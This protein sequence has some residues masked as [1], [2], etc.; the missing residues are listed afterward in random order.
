MHIHDDLKAT[1]A[2][3]T[4]LGYKDHFPQIHLYKLSLEGPVM[5]DALNEDELIDADM[6]ILRHLKLEYREVQKDDR[7]AGPRKKAGVRAIR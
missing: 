4:M 7:D 5:T 2:G 1:V 6:G 3:R